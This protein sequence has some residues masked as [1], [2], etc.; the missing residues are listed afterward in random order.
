MSALE[1]WTAKGAEPGRRERWR[2]AWQE[3][4]GRLMTGGAPADS[5]EG[6]LARLE[7]RLDLVEEALGAMAVDGRAGK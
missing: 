4:A 2:G 3:W 1:P 6:R 5:V 7:A